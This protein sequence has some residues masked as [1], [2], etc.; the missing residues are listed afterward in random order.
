M[1]LLASRSGVEGN[2]SMRGG[3]FSVETPIFIKHVRISY[4]YFPAPLST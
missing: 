1:D 4:L 3:V 2:L